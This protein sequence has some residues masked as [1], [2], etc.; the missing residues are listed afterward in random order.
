M[1]MVSY[2][3]WMF[4]V[5]F[6]EVDLAILTQNGVHLKEHEYHTVKTLLEKGYD[7]KLIPPSKI[8]GLR[9]PDIMIQGLSWEIKSPQGD[10]KKV[11]KNTLQNASHQ[12]QNTIIDLRRCRVD[13][14]RSIKELEHYFILSKRLKRM[15]I[16][17]KTEEIIDFVK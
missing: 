8:K 5:E 14:Q 3:C 12:S 2:L 1:S 6:L 9:M 11:F 4:F 15:K 16:I 17:L 13:E 7:V 10:G